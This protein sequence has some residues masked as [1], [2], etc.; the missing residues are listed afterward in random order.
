MIDRRSFIVGAAALAVA[1]LPALAD[2]PIKTAE[3]WLGYN[4]WVWRTIG[5]DHYHV[6]WPTNFQD[7]P[8]PWTVA[9]RRLP[10]TLPHR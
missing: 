4:G 6:M 1:P 3:Y 9:P 7:S 5:D 10:N 2:I 8:I